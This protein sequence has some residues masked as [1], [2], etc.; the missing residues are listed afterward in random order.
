MLQRCTRSKYVTSYFFV[1]T[2]S[3][4]YFG[5]LLARTDLHTTTSSFGQLSAF[6]IS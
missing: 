5:G 6:D 4:R 2:Y 1:R 3:A